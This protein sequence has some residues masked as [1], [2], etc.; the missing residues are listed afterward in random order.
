MDVPLCEHIRTCVYCEVERRP[1][2]HRLTENDP[3]IYYTSCFY[4]I[5]SGAIDLECEWD[6]YGELVRQVMDG[7]D[8]GVRDGFYGKPQVD[9]ANCNIP[10]LAMLYQTGYQ[11]GTLARHAQ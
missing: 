2:N 7:Y 11:A 3:P 10:E 6:S 8:I 5:L 9:G 1:H 4:C